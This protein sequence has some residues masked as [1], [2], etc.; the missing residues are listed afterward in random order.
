MAL[1]IFGNEVVETVEEKLEK[2]RVP[3][4]FDI[5]NDLC[6]GKHGI[7]DRTTMKGYNP[8]VVG[9]GLSQHLDT[10]LLAY[11]LNKQ[12]VIDPLMHH[13]YLMATVKPKKRYGKW[14]KA[15]EK[16]EDIISLLSTHF[17]VS[18]EQAEE[19]MNIIT[20]DELHIIK[21]QYDEGGKKN[22][23]NRLRI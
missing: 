7:V 18:S 10:V 16:D 6:L 12:G 21:Q 5:L 3:A 15:E 2:E 9:Q 22:G 17:K 14:A 8:F 19:Y 13:D 11:E 1:D 4:L 23:N 20:N